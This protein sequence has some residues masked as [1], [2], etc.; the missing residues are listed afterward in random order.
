MTNMAQEAVVS[1]AWAY[2]KVCSKDILIW[3]SDG[4]KAVA[5]VPV[6]QSNRFSDFV[7]T[8]KSLTMTVACTMAQLSLDAEI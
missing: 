8:G 4:M 5:R 1:N 6:V 2:A 3:I 7:I